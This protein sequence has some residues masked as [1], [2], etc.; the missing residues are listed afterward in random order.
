MRDDYECEG[1]KEKKQ[2][3]RRTKILFIPRTRLPT[4]G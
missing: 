2:R 4:L 3:E 1:E